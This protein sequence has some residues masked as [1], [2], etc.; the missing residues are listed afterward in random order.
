MGVGTGFIKSL[1]KVKALIAKG[2]DNLRDTTFNT[3]FDIP[4]FAI[5]SP[6]VY[7]GR[8]YTTSSGKVVNLYFYAKT[9]TEAD[10]NMITDI[11]NRKLGDAI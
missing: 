7:R 8:N 1:P 5:N 4:E 6:R 10:I 11:I 9:I 2:L 3:S